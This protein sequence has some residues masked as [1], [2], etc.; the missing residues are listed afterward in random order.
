MCLFKKYFIAYNLFIELIYCYVHFIYLFLIWAQCIN[1]SI[2]IILQ[3]CLCL[4]SPVSFMFTSVSLS[5]SLA[6]LTIP[7]AILHH[8]N[9]ISLTSLM[10]SLIICSIYLILL[11]FLLSWSSQ[12]FLFPL[13]ISTFSSLF[14]L[15]SFAHPF[16]A[17]K[18]HSPTSELTMVLYTATMSIMSIL[19]SRNIPGISCDY[20]IQLPLDV[21]LLLRR[22]PSHLSIIEPTYLNV[23]TCSSLYF[24]LSDISASIIPPCMHTMPSVFFAFTL[25]PFL[26]NASCHSTTLL[27]NYSSFSA[28]IP[29]SSVY[30]S[31]CNPPFPTLFLTTSSSTTNGKGLSADP[32]CQPTVTGNSAVPPHSR[33]TLWLLLRCTFLLV[34][35]R[36]VL[37][38][39]SSF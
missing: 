28:N 33:L 13:S 2:S 4:C 32:W 15:E 21:S 8:P 11:L 23:S 17:P 38:L 30:S 14:F 39:F 3:S 16:S 9:Y 37:G 26:S 7:T 35:S 6:I 22:Q 24:F 18:S 5:L 1:F 36:F 31:S 12:S 10:F 27:C 19:L 34:I 20:P 25:R 29:K